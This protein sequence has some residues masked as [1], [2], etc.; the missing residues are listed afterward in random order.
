M[1][2][3]LNDLFHELNLDKDACKRLLEFLGCLKE[4]NPQTYEH[5][6]RVGVMSWSIA[7]FLGLDEKALFFA[8]LLHD[9]GK[10]K[11]DKIL[12]EKTGDFTSAD[13]YEIK[14]HVLDGYEILLSGNFKFTADIILYH[15]CYQDD[16]YPDFFPISEHVYSDED[17]KLIVIYRRVIALAD[18]YDA[19]H[20]S[21]RGKTRSGA[22]IKEEMMQ[23]NSDKIDLIEKLYNDGIFTTRG[24]N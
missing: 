16:A 23:M 20:R 4:K 9:I 18:C 17:K 19:L 8:G 21:D 11:Q 14:K 12:L 1:E 13:R 10:I 24:K 22:K 2:K 15:H 7:R 3:R 6:L 5:S